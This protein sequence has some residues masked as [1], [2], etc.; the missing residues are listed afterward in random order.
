M[1]GGY[2]GRPMPVHVAITE[3]SENH[4]ERWLALFGETAR[5]VC[6]TDAA[7]PFVDRSMRIAES[8]E[9]GIKLSRGDE[10][11]IDT[12]RQKLA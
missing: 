11:V 12:P 7:S 2:K 6:P 5:K 1:S 9:L 10:S 3:I 8:L 4:F